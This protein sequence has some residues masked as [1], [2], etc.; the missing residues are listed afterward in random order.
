MGVLAV[1]GGSG[2][3]KQKKKGES[4]GGGPLSRKGGESSPPAPVAEHPTLSRS[5]PAAGMGS[6]GARVPSLPLTAA[7]LIRGKKE[8]FS[9]SDA[10]K[11]ARENIPFR[12]LAIDETSFKR[13]VNSGLPVEICGSRGSEAANVLAEIFSLL[14]G[15][16]MRKA[17]RSGE[18]RLVGFDES[19]QTE[20]LASAWGGVEPL[21]LKRCA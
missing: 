19:N 20:E 15:A 16:M 11:K 7:V 3:G 2:R 14:P 21:K 12:E 13:T 1:G 5:Q 4:V 17:E 18:V 8:K 10:L 6:V 9:Y